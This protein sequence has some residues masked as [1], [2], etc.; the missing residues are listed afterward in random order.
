MSLSNLDVDSTSNPK[1]SIWIYRHAN[2]IDEEDPKWLSD[3]KFQYDPPLSLNGYDT[4]IKMGNFI[5]NTEKFKLLELEN[6]SDIRL[7]SS[8][9]LR[10]LQTSHI[11]AKTIETHWYIAKSKPID[12]NL[13]ICI[14]YG[15]GEDIPDR[16]LYD[17]SQVISDRDLL[18]N[19]LN[20]DTDLEIIDRID[21][22]YDSKFKANDRLTHATET[23]YKIRVESIYK[24]LI[25]LGYHTILIS[26]HLDETHV[27]YR[28]LAKL[29]IPERRRYG[30]MA[31]FVN[32]SD[33]FMN[34]ENMY[35]KQNDWVIKHH[36]W[37]HHQNI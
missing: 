21:I 27:A 32:K 30:V 3:A 20:P 33:K 23:E 10:C 5:W 2:R 29:N 22:H 31:N 13:K 19:Y 9:F 34:T 26:S 18:I 37:D 8:P 12:N 7:F 6:L 1:S 36:L 14:E 28:Y 16:K 17:P 11:I 4:A 15:L 24:H 35:K 25:N